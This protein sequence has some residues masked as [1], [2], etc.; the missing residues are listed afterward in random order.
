MCKQK[1]WIKNTCTEFIKK[2]DKV[3]V[4]IYCS[5]MVYGVLEGEEDYRGRD[6]DKHFIMRLVN[7]TLN[8]SVLYTPSLSFFSLSLSSLSS[9]SSY[10][11][12]SC[13]S[14]SYS[15]S[16]SWIRTRMDIFGI[17]Y[18]HKNLCGSETLIKT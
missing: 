9:L 18:P 7:N 14:S 4:C 16:F 13:S 17:P 2:F 8:G 3:Y 11:S 1:I 5:E 10:Y 15:Y 6:H 12:S